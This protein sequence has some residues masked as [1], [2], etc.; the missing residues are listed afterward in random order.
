MDLFPSF[1]DLSKPNDLLKLKQI[2]TEL[3][4]DL[5]VLYTT[6]A[7]NGNISAR[8]GRIALYNNAGTYTKWVNVDGL[9][10]WQQIADDTGVVHTTGDES[11]GGV[12]TF[13]SIPVLPAS[14]PTTDNQATRKAY[15]DGKISKSTAGEIAAITEKTSLADDDLFLI[16]DSASSNAKKRV[17]KSNVVPY[18]IIPR[19]IQ[20]FDASGTWTKPASVDQVYVKVW[21]AGGAGGT[22]TEANSKGGGGGGGYA[23][24]LIAVT[25]NVTVTIDST[26]SKFVGST[27][28]EALVGATG[29][30][31]GGA[32]GTASGGTINLTGAAGTSTKASTNGASGGS[33]GGSPMGGGGGGGGVSSNS[34]NPNM[35]GGAGCIPGGG[36]GGGSENGGAGGAGG[37][38]LVVVY[39]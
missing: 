21:G 18:E 11:V 14:D 3:A 36:G 25:G 28:I 23:E 17:K 37:G 13:T 26:S 22:A 27:T 16:E 5:D 32:G 29:T 10:T 15:V 12:K 19:N 35:A 30:G 1:M 4:A 6:T 31:T 20:V 9:L 24:G 38:G 34:D 2:I 7:P 33:G 8:Q 39:Y